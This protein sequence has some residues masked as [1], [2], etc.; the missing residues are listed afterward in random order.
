MSF[1]RQGRS[2]DKRHL[3]PSWFSPRGKRPGDYQTHWLGCPAAL[4]FPGSV[5]LRYGP[6]RACH[7][8][9]G[10][11]ASPAGKAG[12][13]RKAAWGRV[14]TYRVYTVHCTV[15]SAAGAGAT[16][17]TLTKRLQTNRTSLSGHNRY[18]NCSVQDNTRSTMPSMP[19]SG[20]VQEPQAQ[21]PES[22]FLL[23]WGSLVLM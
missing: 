8:H 14:C 7:G 11:I 6:W 22:I 15:Y 5:A 20:T 21:I 17:H 1:S 18:G 4:P 16:G 12:P 19:C 13:V 10:G 2:P 23:N 9:D 3:G